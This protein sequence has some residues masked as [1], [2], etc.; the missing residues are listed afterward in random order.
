MTD[1]GDWSAA[2][3][4]LLDS[5]L[6]FYGA[7]ETV[8]DYSGS[9]RPRLLYDVARLQKVRDAMAALEA[10]IRGAFE[11]GVSAERITRITRLEREIVDLILG[12]SAA[13]SAR[14]TPP[15]RARQDATGG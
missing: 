2:E 7:A 1:D 5:A 10:R 14:P 9:E 3:R 4:A 6:D 13:R 15:R 8:I 11:S 12:R